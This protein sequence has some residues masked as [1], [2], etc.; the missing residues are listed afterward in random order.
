MEGKYLELFNKARPYL[1]TRD[2]II[3]TTVA[4]SFALKLLD[5]EGG[6]ADI[7]LPA[8]ILHDVGWSFIPEQLHLKAFGPGE[9]DLDLNRIHEEEGSRKAR[10]ILEEMGYEPALIDEISEIILGH[11]SR[12]QPLSLNDAIVKDS[13]RLWRYSEDALRIDPKRF[14][15][16]P[17]IHA[18]WLK[19]QIDK[20]FYTETAKRLAMEEQ[21]KR[22]LTY[23]P[24]PCP[25]S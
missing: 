3:H 13:D 4:Y 15:I 9:S 19:H 6:E 12:E 25:D 20:W 22:A 18:E 14:N 24:P 1:E 16:H 8:V 11:D 2:N 10:E 17:G 23:P 21:S 7:V 5:A